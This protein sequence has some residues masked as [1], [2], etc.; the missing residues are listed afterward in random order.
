MGQY[1]QWLHY[2][3]VDQQLHTLKEH[4]LTELQHIY[5]Q[6]AL[7]TSPLDANNRIVQALLSYTKKTSS[8]P[9]TV[10]QQLEV[11]DAQRIDTISL[12]FERSRLPNLEPMFENTAQPPQPTPTVQPTKTFAPLPPLPHQSQAF[13]PEETNGVLDNQQQT[14]P[15]TALPWWLRKAALAAP[16]NGLD[17][18]SVRTN[19]LVQR[20]LERWGR[21]ENDA[22]P[23]DSNG[24]GYSSTHPGEEAKQ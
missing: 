21:Q 12:L 20:W 3:Q 7:H 11:T 14:E 1:R 19:Q 6:N 18:Q 22:F 8:V 5:E 16:G 13:N 9:N 10:E 2:R 24:N 23:E 15:Q 4:L 17:Q